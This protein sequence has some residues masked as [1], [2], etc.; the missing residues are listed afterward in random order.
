[1]SVS[2]KQV[3]AV[4][5]AAE[6]ELV[7]HSRRPRLQQLQLA[8]ARKCARRTRGL[9]DK[10]Q[11]LAR[12][13]GRAQAKQGVGSDAAQRT[14]LKARVFREALD[15]FEAHI[16]KLTGGKAT[17]R[18]PARSETDQS[19]KPRKSGP[20]APSPKNEGEELASQPAAI[21]QG[22]AHAEP[23]ETSPPDSAGT[24][25]S[26]ARGK[27]AVAHDGAP[28]GGRV[29]RSRAGLRGVEYS[30]GGRG[31]AAGQRKLQANARALE[32]RIAA[33]GKTTRVRGH[34]SAR[35]RRKQA[36]RDGG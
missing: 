1:M 9:F 24:P 35:G 8:E 22:S 27:Q 19:A 3:K 10:W 33:S 7:Q 26:R 36:R 25:A 11:G 30:G 17:G 5:T 34:V 31:N 21:P 14:Q 4:C 23:G 18:G 6:F 29:R 2:S 12:Q 13:Q 32:N 28:S 16:A 15:A 20:G